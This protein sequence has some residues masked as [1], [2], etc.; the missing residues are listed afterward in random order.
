MC[1]AFGD[2]KQMLNHRVFLKI[3][4]YFAMLTLRKVT[5]SEIA[6]NA[7][8]SLFMAFEVERKLPHEIPQTGFLSTFNIIWALEVT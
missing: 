6:L 8:R 4:N 7:L 2:S 3:K 1:T 5:F